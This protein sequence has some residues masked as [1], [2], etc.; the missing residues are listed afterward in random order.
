M[1]SCL[2]AL[3]ASGHRRQEHLG[4]TKVIVDIMQMALAQQVTC[5]SRQQEGQGWEFGAVQAE[6]PRCLPRKL[7]QDWGTR[8]AHGG[9]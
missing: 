4:R 6:A 5:A 3:D 8:L 2:I 1:P 7:F 9:G